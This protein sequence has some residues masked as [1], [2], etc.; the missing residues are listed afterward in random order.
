[1]KWFALS[2]LFCLLA[3]TPVIASFETEDPLQEIEDLRTEQNL[4]NAEIEAENA[5]IG[6]GSI[7]LEKQDYLRLLVSSYVNGFKEFDT[8]VTTTDN[9]V[10]VSVYYDSNQQSQQK[11]DQLAKRFR[12]KIQQILGPYKWAENVSVIV[13]VTTEDRNR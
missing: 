12:E 8:G 6:T 4:E 7:Y 3:G 10:S 13:T 1:M 11:A 5:K 2:V 9:S